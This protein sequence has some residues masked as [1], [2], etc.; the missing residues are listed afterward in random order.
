MTLGFSGAPAEPADEAR[1]QSHQFSA[2]KAT[3]SKAKKV[4]YPLPAG[5]AGADFLWLALM[6]RAIQCPRKGRAL[7]AH[8]AK[9]KQDWLKRLQYIAAG[10]PLEVISSPLQPSPQRLGQPEMNHPPQALPLKG[11]QL[12]LRLSVTAPQA[13][14]KLLDLDAG[15]AGHAGLP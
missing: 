3:T 9:E 4:R 14:L 15:I 10:Q 11:E 13:A 1:R 7:S 8:E 2:A 12:G 5:G 6:S